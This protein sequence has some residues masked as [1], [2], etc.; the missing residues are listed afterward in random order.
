MWIN[1]SDQRIEEFNTIQTKYLGTT[2]DHDTTSLY[3]APSKPLKLIQDVRTRWD[4]SCHMLVRLCQLRQSVAEMLERH[5]QEHMLP[6]KTEW[7]QIEYLIQLTKPFALWTQSLSAS[8]G[9]SAF[10]VFIAYNQVFDVIEK[11][12]ARTK[13]KSTPWKRDIHNGLDKAHAKLRKYYSETQSDLGDLY[14][15]AILLHPTRKKSF[16]THKEWQGG[17]EDKYWASLKTLFMERYADEGVDGCVKHPTS[18]RR[19]N[20]MQGVDYLLGTEEDLSDNDEFDGEGDVVDIDGRWRES[21]SSEFRRWR[22]YGEFSR[23]LPET[24]QNADYGPEYHDSQQLPVESILP[25]WKTL[26]PQFPRIARMARDIHSVPA[27]GVGVEQ[28]FSQARHQGRFNRT[29]S[30]DAF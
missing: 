1:H 26:E 2:L 22:A 11:A 7:R 6:S 8:S 16:F 5:S 27:A 13:H 4:S 30:K 23:G 10:L 14:G 9:P 12:M 15:H 28:M 29:Y 24:Y 25:A 17:W 18:R 3:T 21:P 20:D 19:F